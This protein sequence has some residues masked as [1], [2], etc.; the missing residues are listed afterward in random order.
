VALP[1]IALFAGAF[2]LRL[3][4]HHDSLLYPDGYQYL[5]M[6]RGIA[7]HLEPTTVLGPGGDTFVP[8][9]DAA[10]KP[11]YPL[12]VAGAHVFGVSWLTAAS[13][14]TAAAAAAVVVLAALLAAVVGRSAWAGAAAGLLLLASPSL[15]FWSGFSGPDPVAQ[16]LALA[17]AL[18][19]VYRRPVV[20]G[21]LAGLAIAT[22]PELALVALAAAAVALRRADTRADVRRAV[23]A[24]AVSLALVFGTLRPPVALPD[25]ELVVLAVI[26]LGCLLVVAFAP[27][28]MARYAVVAALGV[29]TV[30][31]VGSSGVAELWR[32][33]WPLLALAAVGLLVL[34]WNERGRPTAGVLVGCVLLLGAVYAVKNPALERYFALLLPCA[35]LL[36]GIAVARAPARARPLALGVIALAVTVGFLRPIPGSRDYDAFASIAERVEPS[37]PTSAVLVTAAPDAYGFLLPEHAV[38]EMRPGARGAILLDPAQRLYAPGLRA[39]GEVVLRVVDEVAFARPDGELDASPAVLVRGDVVPAHPAAAPHAG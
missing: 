15:G 2:A 17:A 9:P 20:G 5:F 39:K 10:A 19:F 13:L 30:V 6:A 22:R 14:V 4:Q 12:A 27:A 37:L 34:A 23:P 35:A 16:A 32:H 25:L 38:R 29:A 26:A 7:E 28:A 1:P 24:T 11:V 36:V 3:A 8:S 33:D 18:G 21:A 31:V